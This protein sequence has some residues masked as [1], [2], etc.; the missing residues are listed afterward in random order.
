MSTQ[1]KLQFDQLEVAVVENDASSKRG[2]EQTLAE[3]G[4]VVV[5]VAQNHDEARSFATEHLPDIVFVDLRLLRGTDDHRPGWYLIQDLHG[6]DP[7]VAIIVYSGTPVID[8]IVVDAIRLGCSY[9]IKE[10]IWEQEQAVIAGALLAACTRSVL[11]S[12][13]V[14]SS[15]ASVTRKKTG[16]S[17]LTDRELDV[18]ELVA[19]SL[20]NQE[21]A[22]RLVIG[23]S[24]VKT[25]ISNILSKL[26]VKNRTKAAD[27]YRQQYGG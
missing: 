17:M 13:E 24:T 23:T 20:T 15:I 12:N 8:D 7:H 19:D 3:L 2:L 14:T 22:E 26:G 11:L 16:G 25:H 10:D 6:L 1:F 21:I 18:L 9:V 27:W 4:C 5:W